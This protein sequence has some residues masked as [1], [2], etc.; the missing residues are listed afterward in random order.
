MKQADCT[1]ITNREGSTVRKEDVTPAEV[2]YLV[3]S[4]NRIG[5]IPVP[6]AE[7]TNKRNIP[8]IGKVIIP[9]P[10]GPIETSGHVQCE[11]PKKEATAY[12]LGDY[13][14]IE[15][16]KEVERTDYEELQRLSRK[17][18][19]DHLKALFNPTDPRMPKD[20]EE[21]IQ[22]GMG[23]GQMGDSMMNGTLTTFQ[24]P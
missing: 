23:I 10:N 8:K 2:M 13:E 22:K 14:E 21:A 5:K 4:Y 1:V 7:I 6:L 3:A 20:F 9:S 12:K 15:T 19:G 17:Y 18:R 16:V 11:D 24:F